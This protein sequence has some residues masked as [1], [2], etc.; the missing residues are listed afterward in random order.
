MI[1]K[2]FGV[3][4]AMATPFT[5]DFRLEFDV[6]PGRGTEVVIRAPASRLE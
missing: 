2:F 4:P 5:H 3:V 1:D 6:V